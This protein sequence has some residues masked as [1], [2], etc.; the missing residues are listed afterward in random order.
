MAVQISHVDEDNDAKEDFSVISGKSGAVDDG[1]EIKDEKK[2]CLFLLVIGADAY[3]LLKHLVLATVLSTMTYP[4]LVRE[5]STHDNPAPI[6]ITE[7]FR[8]QKRYQKEDDTVSD[9]VVALKQLAATCD[10]G[11]YLDDALRDHFVSG[12]R[13]DAVQCRLLPEKDLTFPKVCE[14]AATM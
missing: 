1:K 5:L 3:K 8:F 9:Y 12:M 4:E 6:V 7:R 2:V 10:F 14:V 11:Q 13:S